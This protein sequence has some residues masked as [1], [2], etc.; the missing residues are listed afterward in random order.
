MSDNLY[1]LT[2]DLTKIKQ[3]LEFVTDDM[4]AALP[5]CCGPLTTSGLLLMQDLEAAVALHSRIENHLSAL[6][7][8]MEDD[9]SND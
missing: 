2:E 7:N 8:P 4:R 9:E 6:Q 1:M 5:R 3:T